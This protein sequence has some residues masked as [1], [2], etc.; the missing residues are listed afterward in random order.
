MACA[1]LKVVSSDKKRMNM[2]SLSIMSSLCH[3]NNMRKTQDITNEYFKRR[4]SLISLSA[5]YEKFAELG[6]QRFTKIKEEPV[7]RSES[8]M[9]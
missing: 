7:F 5:T 6:L 4:V 9:R 2:K 1:Q 3:N 8:Q